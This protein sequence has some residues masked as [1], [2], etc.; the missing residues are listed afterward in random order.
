MKALGAFII[1][2]ANGICDGFICI[3]LARRVGKCLLNTVFSFGKSKK[4]S[5]LHFFVARKKK[6][7]KVSRNQ[8]QKQKIDEVREEV[9]ISLH[10]AFR[11]NFEA[12]RLLGGH[13]KNEITRSCNRMRPCRKSLSSGKS[14]KTGNGWGGLS[15]PCDSAITGSP[16]LSRVF[17]SLAMQLRLR[18]IQ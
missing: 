4:Y 10:P 1:F 16:R 7:M 14:S 6:E 18:D 12:I 15:K 5:R 11:S 17:S 3:A 8:G 2:K 9:L 13:L